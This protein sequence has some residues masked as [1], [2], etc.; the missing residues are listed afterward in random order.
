MKLFHGYLV[1]NED[2]TE[3][4]AALSEVDQ[5]AAEEFCAKYCRGRTTQLCKARMPWTSYDYI[6][7]L[8]LERKGKAAAQS[9]KMFSLE[10]EHIRKCENPGW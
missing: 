2:M 8:I 9:A 10:L 7:D 5:Y 1:Y 3:L 4:V 6:S